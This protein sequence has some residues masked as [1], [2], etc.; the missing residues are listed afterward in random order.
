LAGLRFAVNGWQFAVCSWGVGHISRENARPFNVTRESPMIRGTKTSAPSARRCFSPTPSVNGQRP[1]ANCERQPATPPRRTISGGHDNT[2]RPG[3]LCGHGRG[4]HIVGTWSAVG[5][6]SGWRLFASEVSSWTSFV[7]V[8]PLVSSSF[9]SLIRLRL[10]THLAG[11]AL[12]LPPPDA[13]PLDR[14]K[15]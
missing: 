6:A 5:R 4:Y 12:F 13:V 15:L 1:T 3:M 7:L 8:H 10:P 11:L 9:L 14:G 2:R